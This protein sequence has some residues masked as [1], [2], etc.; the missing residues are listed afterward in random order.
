VGTITRYAGEDH[1]HAG[2][3]SISVVGNTSGNVTAGA[4]SLVL[5]GGNNVTLSGATAAGGMTL[6]ISAANETQTVPPIGT[7]VK[8]VSSIGSTGTV[9]RFAPEDH[10]HAGLHSINVGGNTA[11]ATSA[12]AGSFLL[13]GGD[14]VTLSGATAAGGMT[15]SIMGATAAGGAG[16]SAGMSN[17]GNTLGTSGTVGSRLVFAGGS[18][19]TLSQS[20]NGASATLTVSAGF[21]RSF[22]EIGLV[23]AV[24]VYSFTR[25]PQQPVFF[26]FTIDHAGLSAKTIRQVMSRA[27][28]V[29]LVA[30]L[31][32]GFYSMVNATSLALVSSTTQNYSLAS[33]ASWNQAR[34]YD[35]TGLSNLTFSAGH[36]WMGLHLSATATGQG[37]L[38]LMGAVPAVAVNGVISPGTE[39][40]QATTASVGVVPFYGMLSFSSAS[41][42]SNVA[43][44]DMLGADGSTAGG[45]PY[46]A[47]RGI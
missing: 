30:T 11:G 44:S 36:W 2:L 34:V 38:L 26:P 45:L 43:Q 9:T 27:A 8:G 32:V 33:S 1:A 5:A 23:P 20:V 14:N 25:G 13:A 21:G 46:V 22:T 3:N 6:S 17:L 42:P 47:I 35:V 10:Q 16:F 31:G 37:N 41:L 39:S 28:G 15:L 29:S 24:P 4:G 40:T 19:V 18:N 7:A 12:G